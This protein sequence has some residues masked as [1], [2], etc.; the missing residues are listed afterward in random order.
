MLMKDCEY[1]H[2]CVEQY[3]N[4][5]VKSVCVISKSCYIAI[6]D[7]SYTDQYYYIHALHFRQRD[8]IS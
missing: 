5:W 4:S 1:V 2:V 8:K 7:I 3:I 6:M